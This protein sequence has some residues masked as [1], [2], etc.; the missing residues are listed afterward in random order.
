ML[1]AYSYIIGRCRWQWMPFRQPLLQA[2]E[3]DLNKHGGQHKWESAEILV[4]CWAANNTIVQWLRLQSNIEWF[5]HPPPSYEQ[6]LIIFIWAVDGRKE[7]SS[8]HF[9]SATCTPQIWK[10][11]WSYGSLLGCNW[12]HCAVA[13]ALTQHEMLPTPPSTIWKVVDKLHMLWMGIWRHHEAM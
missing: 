5:P 11:F 12:H 13:E 7:L 10:V 8:G 9:T 6:C 2:G 1:L 4:H 3:T